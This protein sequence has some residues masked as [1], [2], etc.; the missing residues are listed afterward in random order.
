MQH[1]RIGFSGRC[2]RTPAGTAVIVAAGLLLA[3][4]GGAARAN[5]HQAPVRVAVNETPLLFEGQGPIERNGR[6]LVP[7]RGVMERLGAFVRYDR[8]T[9]TVT[10]FRGATNITL[11]VGSRR[12]LIGD[13]A[14]SLETPAQTVNGS[15]LVPLRFVAEALGARVT[16]D[17]GAR[18]VAIA[19]AGASQA[20]AAAPVVRA[21]S[22]TPAPEVGVATTGIVVA[23]Y[24][25][26]VP[27][28][29]VVRVPRGSGQSAEAT[30]AGPDEVTI[31]L[32][33]DA[34]VAVRRPSTLLAITLDR[35]RAGDTVEVQQTPEGVATLIEV[36]ARAAAA[37]ASPD[38]N[39]APD[40]ANANDAAPVAP[41]PA[42]DPAPPPK[43]VPAPAATPPA[44]TPTTPVVSPPG[45]S[46]AAAANTLRGEFLEASKLKNEAYVLKMTDGRLIEVPAN[47]LILYSGQRIGVGDLRSGDRLT[48]A[49]D[50]KTRRGTRV[51]V[52]PE[53]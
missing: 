21:P 41:A 46:A 15:V 4:S 2:G 40:P 11:P 32:R 25:D 51:T 22:E 13:R 30:T 38:E 9:R 33:P 5:S 35:V 39:G 27:R 8:L 3:S 29:I 10:A 17:T 52:A 7:L 34:R 12:A 45:P 19:L 43:N 24:P 47:V 18:A 49:V 1:L 37:V 53:Q 26:L 16:Y 42:S 28:R 44:P 20:P 50:P 31:P 14:V 6:V 48:I 36:T 23:V